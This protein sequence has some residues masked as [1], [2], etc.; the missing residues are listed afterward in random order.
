MK[1]Y[2]LKKWYKNKDHRTF[3]YP[4]DVDKEL[5]PMLDV[6][7]NIPGVRTIYSC[8][9]HGFTEW[10]MEFKTTSDFMYKTICDYFTKL[11]NESNLFSS[12]NF[13]VETCDY[14]QWGIVPEKRITVYSSKLGKL[15]SS[16]RKD[17]YRKICEFFS[18]FTPDAQWK[19]IQEF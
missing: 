8:C 6:F 11:G 19:N 12:V 3:K 17:E 4:N 5:I 15:N 16:K 1:N 10:Y 14:V 7:N 9:G 18:K 13:R 2:V